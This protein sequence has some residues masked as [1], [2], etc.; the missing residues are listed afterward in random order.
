MLK[1]VTSLTGIHRV[2][3]FFLSIFLFFGS[4]SAQVYYAKV[5]PYEVKT[6]SSNVS[7]EVVFLN[8]DL[9]GQKLHGEHYLKIDDTLDVA[10]YKQVQNKKIYVA[11]IIE[12][13]E[14]I[15]VNLA[16]A[17]EIKEKNFER[18]SALKIKSQVEKDKE[19]YDLIAS[20]N[21]LL[22]TQKEIQNLKVQLADLTFREKQLQKT[23]NDKNLTAKGYVLYSLDVKK[24]Q[25]VTP[26][27]MLAKVA[28]T[29]KALLKFYVDA[30]ELEDLEK[31]V[32]Y[33]DEQRTPYKVS[34]VLQIADEKNISKYMV[35]I[36]TKAPQV[37]SQLAKIELKEK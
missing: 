5:E 21:Q 13:N 24:G 8:E 29:S 37:F 23:Q 32:V 33:I 6:V 3:K 34:R 22:S 35:Q 31:K 11:Q 1:L 25:V 28:D 26:G 4:L 27:V 2:M 18:V 36:I 14:K 15:L 10:E 30:S 7:G 16:Q 9:L 19:F 20:R 17:L 12:A